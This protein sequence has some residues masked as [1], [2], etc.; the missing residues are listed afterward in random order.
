MSSKPPS[1]PP[2]VERETQVEKPGTALKA[3]LGETPASS[4][5]GETTSNETR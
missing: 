1:V 2:D 4:E 5:P 3:L